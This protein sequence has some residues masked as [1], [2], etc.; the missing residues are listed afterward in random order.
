MYNSLY[1]SMLVADEWRDFAR[2]RK[3]IRVT[4]PAGKQ[5]SSYFLQLPYA[6]AVPLMVFSGLMHW[7]VSQSLFLANVTVLDPDGIQDKEASIVTCGYSIIAI[8]F[9]VIIGGL[10]VVAVVAIGFRRFEPRMPLTSNRNMAI[11]AAYHAPPEDVDAA[12]LPLMWGV[13][14]QVTKGVSHCSFTS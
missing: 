3:T 10:M 14:K 13:V 1:T 2:Q 6:Y 8:M 4:S 9:T 12:I 7:L 11:S 5:R